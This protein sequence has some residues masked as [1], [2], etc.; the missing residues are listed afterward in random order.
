MHTILNIKLGREVFIQLQV[1]DYV[2]SNKHRSLFFFNN[3]IRV[4]ESNKIRYNS[5]KWP[6]R[7]KSKFILFFGVEDI[8]TQAVELLLW[9]SSQN[10]GLHNV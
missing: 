9:N 4:T 10:I 6:L 1:V 8:L 7:I 2:L 3:S 5:A